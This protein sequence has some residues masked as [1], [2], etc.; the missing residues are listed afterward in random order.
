MILCVLA[1]PACKQTCL[2]TFTYCHIINPSLIPHQCTTPSLYD[3]AG[4]LP[5]P[6]PTPVQVQLKPCLT[7]ASAKGP[8]QTKR[9][10]CKTIKANYDNNNENK[11]GNEQE[12]A[13]GVE[14][15]NDKDKDNPPVSR[16]G[17]RGRAMKK[18]PPR[19][20]I[21]HDHC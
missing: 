11:S 6:S 21:G 19:R 18:G 12:A 17:R 5:N 8:M 13:D 16:G 20:Y 15:D 2:Y 3:C 9:T 1:C 14:D 7:H 4:C 10:R